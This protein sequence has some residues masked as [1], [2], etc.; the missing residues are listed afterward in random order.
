[1]NIKENIT[2]LRDNVIKLIEAKF[3]LGKLEIQDKIEWVAVKV[4]YGLLMAFLGLMALIFINIIIA[5]FINDLLNS[6]YWG[7]VICLLLD[8]LFLLILNFRKE[9]IQ[10]GIKH[11][12]EKLVD[13][14]MNKPKQK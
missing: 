14:I 13:E 10:S 8:V 3:E 1:M 9:K 4:F 5:I 11:T 12:V 6:Q 7:Y 2:D